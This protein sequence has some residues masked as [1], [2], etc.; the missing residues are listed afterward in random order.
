[1]V[2]YLRIGEFAKLGRVSVKALRFYEAEGLLKPEYTSPESGYR[3]YTVEQCS[4]L[5]IIT[6]L[7]SAGFS[8]REIGE[9]LDAGSD[10][11]AI[12]QIADRRRDRLETEKRELDRQLVILESLTR[13]IRGDDKDP[14]SSVR[15]MPV[16]DQQ[17]H[18]VRTTVPH[19]GSPVTEIFES[20]EAAVAA[21]DAR[22]PNA[23]FLIFHDQPSKESDIC[24]EVC[25]PLTEEGATRIDNVTVAGCDSGCSVI[26]GGD[27]SQTE[28]LSASMT[29]WIERAGLVAAGPV[30]EIYHRFGA[31]R[32]GYDLPDAVVTKTSDEFITELLQP[33][34]TRP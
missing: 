13:S 14:L 9:A 11:D 8:I 24:L 18:S 2:R 31:D 28:P 33:V 19:L 22:S 16:P 17:V 15:L 21:V 5:A 29:G 10:F 1:M 3:Y 27:Y 26:Y 6:N 23:P 4:E 12:L 34:T 30:R 25:I 32:S 20:T 7:R